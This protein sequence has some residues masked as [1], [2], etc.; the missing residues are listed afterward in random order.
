MGC[1]RSIRTSSDAIQ[2]VVIE[3][4]LMETRSGLAKYQCIRKI[5]DLYSCVVYNGM[6]K[7]GDS[8]CV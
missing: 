1:G 2:Y 8:S 7:L 5:I 4:S 3:E 6:L